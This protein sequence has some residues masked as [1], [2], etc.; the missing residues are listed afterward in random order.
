MTKNISTYKE[1]ST[2]D[3]FK[4]SVAYAYEKLGDP[5]VIHLY[6]QYRNHIS[7]QILEV[8]HQIQTQLSEEKIPPIHMPITYKWEEYKG[9]SIEILS[10]DPEKIYEACDIQTRNEHIITN[11]PYIDW[12]ELAILY[13]D[14]DILNKVCYH[15]VHNFLIPN[16][17]YIEGFDKENFKI[18]WPKEWYIHIVIT[19]IWSH[20][21][22]LC[23]DNRERLSYTKSNKFELQ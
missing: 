16:W 7:K 11:L 20:I 9:F 6:K 14:S 15:I 23:E 17:L 4:D 3:N 8:Y 2:W 22:R 19:D 12:D 18:L 5:W 13:I 21:K 1:H 10:L